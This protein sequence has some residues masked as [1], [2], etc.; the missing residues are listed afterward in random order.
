M[1]GFRTLVIMILAAVLL[2]GC[3]TRKKYENPI[4]RDT[5]QPDKI[6]FDK[7]I[8]D[9]EKGRF[10]VSRLTLNTLINTYD[11]SE[12]MAKA[13]LALADSWFREGGPQGLAQAEAEYKDFILF[14]PTLEEAPEAQERICRIHYRQMEKPDRDQMH[15]IRADDECRQLVIQ[16]RGNDEFER[17]T[18]L[19]LEAS[20][21]GVQ[22]FAS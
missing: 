12:F 5:A 1:T 21:D 15:S 9:L 8:K 7:A 17:L 4:D 3:F 10:I 2:T 19:L 14:Y 11:T 18:E 16:F 20:G 6:L 22:T 13:K